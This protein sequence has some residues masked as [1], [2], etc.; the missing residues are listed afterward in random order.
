MTQSLVRQGSVYTIVDSARASAVLPAPCV[1]ALGQLAK[2]PTPWL[3]VS[4]DSK[5]PRVTDLIKFS[6]SLCI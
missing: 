2:K 1:R 5:R 4:G 6:L 3:S